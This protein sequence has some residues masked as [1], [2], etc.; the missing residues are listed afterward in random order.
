VLRPRARTGTAVSGDGQPRGAPG[1][2]LGAMTLDFDACYRALASRDPRFDGRF[3]TGVLTT[4]IYCRP[5]CPARLPKPE[6]VRFLPSAAAAERAGLRACRRC[7]PEAAPPPSAAAEHS[8]V[9]RRALRLIDGGFLDRHT[10][11]ALA[12]ELHVSERQLRRILGAQVGAGPAEIA[13]TRRAGLAR[14]LLDQTDMPIARV[15]A[16]AGY[17]S[18]RRFN[19]EIRTGFGAT[20]TQLRRRRGG[21]PD[22]ALVLR[23]AY[24]PP[25]DWAHLLGFLAARAVPG[26][27]TVADG[28]YRRTAVLGGR[29]AVVELRPDPA[30]PRAL[31]TIRGAGAGAVAEAA[32][33]ARRLA[34]LDADPMAVEAVLGRDPAVAGSASAHPGLRVPGAWD[35]F[36]LA[37]RAVLGQQVSVASATAL[38]GR[39]A[40]RLGEPLP[41]P[42]GALRLRFPT[43]RAIAGAPDDAL[44]VPAGRRRAL[45]ALAT[46][47]VD[48]VLR[49]DDAAD[50][51]ATRAALT[52]LPGIGPWTADYIAMR[53]LRDPDAFPAGD[54]IVRRMLDCADA[55][56]AR[57]RTAAWAPWRAYG[58]VHLWNSALEGE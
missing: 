7:R 16:E 45:R 25:L 54:L 38:A 43:P 37:V 11:G 15:A 10:V 32:A 27:E 24:R 17:G 26:V 13:R 21:R 35:A 30:H 9:T 58:A 47:V 34:D 53:A 5:V 28:A 33:R 20:P 56:G 46:A 8:V 49:L 51:D 29:P 3:V 19:D 52:A 14:M 2:T 50:P 31:L 6:H 22:A 42:D 12:R 1:A 44:P 55:A 41:H 18:I 36:E 48:G 4:G 40:E 39:L 57:A 23:L